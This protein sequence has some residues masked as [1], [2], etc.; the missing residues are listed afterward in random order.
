MYLNAVTKQSPPFSV[1]QKATASW[2]QRGK[3]Y[4]RYSTVVTNKSPAKTAKDLHLSISGLY[5]P[6][7][8]LD[9][10]RYGYT[11]PRWLNSLAAG[12]SF[13]FVY[14]HAASAADVEVS[15]YRLV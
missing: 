11:F 15:G 6:V 12:E 4:Y 10:S 1:E 9:K 5:G 3:T 13:E 7:W 14:I 2:K 8:G